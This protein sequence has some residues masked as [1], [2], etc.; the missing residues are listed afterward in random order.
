MES[1]MH[2]Q[3]GFTA[4]ELSTVIAFFAIVGAI[5]FVLFHFISKFW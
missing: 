2:N 3:K 5:C 1:K 4:V